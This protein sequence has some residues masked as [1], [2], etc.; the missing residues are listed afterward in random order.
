[1]VGAPVDGERPVL[2]SLVL[3]VLAPVKGEESVIEACFEQFEEMEI[4]LEVGIVDIGVAAPKGEEDYIL[5]E[6]EA[7]V[8][9]NRIGVEG[10]GI[11]VVENRIGVEGV[12]PGSVFLHD[13]VPL[14]TE[15]ERA[16]AARR[17]G[18]N[19]G[20]HWIR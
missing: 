2:Q 8:V 4:V 18:G 16:W 5:E 3:W 13:E 6:V 15:E 1:M 10:V 17:W 14:Y 20:I 12:D 7:V 11:V 9:G 19:I